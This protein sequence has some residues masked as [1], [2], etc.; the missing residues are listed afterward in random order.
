MAKD[1]EDD[2]GD[3]GKPSVGGSLTSEHRAL[4]EG[5]NEPVFD[6]SVASDVDF[7][8]N[9]L[10]QPDGKKW[11]LPAWARILWF[12]RNCPGWRIVTTQCPLPSDNTDTL[13]R[14]RAEILNPDGEVMA[15]AHKTWSLKKNPFF[16]ECAESGAVARA[17]EYLGFTPEQCMTKEGRMIHMK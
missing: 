3:D 12:R 2:W 5:N 17:L 1:E 8:K 9:V 4:S 7:P 11:A 15:T 10:F 14:F 13:A 16:N 6:T